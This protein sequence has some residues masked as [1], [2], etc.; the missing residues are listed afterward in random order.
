MI[1]FKFLR[2]Y[3]RFFRK[4]FVKIQEDL[5]KLGKI[6]KDSLGFIM[7]QSDSVQVLKIIFTTFKEKILEDS[8]T[9]RKIKSDSER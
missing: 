7:I 8:E 2:S 6:Q 4:R 9:F 3:S 1:K 5:E